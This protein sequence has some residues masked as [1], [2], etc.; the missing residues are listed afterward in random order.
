MDKDELKLEV[1]CSE[2]IQLLSIVS[3]EAS[4]GTVLNETRRDWRAIPELAG[5][6]QDYFFMVPLLGEITRTVNT[7]ENYGKIIVSKKTLNIFSFG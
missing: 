1:S 6:G 5:L 2:N 7:F 3:A 4:P